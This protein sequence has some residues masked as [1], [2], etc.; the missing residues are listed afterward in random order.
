MSVTPNISGF[1]EAQDSLIDQLGDDVIITKYDPKVYDP[2]VSLNEDG[3]PFDPTAVPISGGDPHTSVVRVATLKRLL[4]RGAADSV[5]DNPG[6][7]MRDGHAAIALKI[8]DAAELDGAELVTMSG[9]D[10]RVT[11]VIPDSIVGITY[12]HVVYLERK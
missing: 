4:A 6:G 5:E 7:V 10:Y 2:S 8:V 12:R 3:S 9:L 1:I 11:D